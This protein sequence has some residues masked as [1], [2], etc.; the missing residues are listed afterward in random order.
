MRLRRALDRV[1]P[2]H[3]LRE[4]AENRVKR[5]P[6]ADL[7]DWADM[8][9][10]VVARALSRHRNQASREALEEAA[11]GVM[12]LSVILQELLNRVE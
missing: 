12:S 2:N 6:A 9:G 5:L 8:S 4:R 1:W 3:P 11:D 7:L 10:T